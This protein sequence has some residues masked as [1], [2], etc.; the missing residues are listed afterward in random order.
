MLTITISTRAALILATVALT[1]AAA[2]PFAVSRAEGGEPAAVAS[3]ESRAPVST[4]FQYQGRLELDGVPA[5]GTHTLGFTL[6]S[7]AVA[8]APVDSPITATVPVTD[9]V[10]SVPLDFGEDAFNGDARW[11]GV[12]V[13][14]GNSFVPLGPRQA[15]RATPYALHSLT[16]GPHDHI[17]DEWENLANGA[18]GLW[19]NSQ[20]FNSKSL[21]LT[22]TGNCSIAPRVCYGLYSDANYSG[23]GS[24]FGG[25]GVY[26]EGSNAG[27]IGSGPFIGMY[28]SSPIT[29]LQAESSG[30]LALKAMATGLAAGEYA[31]T[32]EATGVGDGLSVKSGGDGI[33]V[34]A[35]GL[36]VRSFGVA[37]GLYGYASGS[38]GTG[39][40]GIANVNQGI[41]VDGY[42]SSS[43]GTG[44]KGSGA[45]V[46]VWG[47]LL[48]GSGWAGYFDGGA[49]S[50]SGG[51]SGPSDIRL[52]HN[53]RDLNSALAMVKALRPV[54]FEYNS[55]PGERL[56]LIAQEV[57]EVV[58]EVVTVD[59]LTEEGMLGV[60]YSE[61]VPVL[62]KA[63]Q[64]QQA[65]IEML[66]AA[67]G[68]E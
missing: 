25:V 56:G 26:G 41:G 45:N 24:G 47:N 1:L 63:M 4:A 57:Q 52:K 46:G 20:G 14:V 34:D 50:S 58:P 37:A 16:T 11:L 13:L 3:V 10:F 40:V 36:G 66:K 44:V 60:K 18:T 42:S 48:D 5:N 38:L 7:D 64:E 31:A 8:N 67:L 9:G 54:R 62:I 53:V 49:V 51:Y 65:E 35:A 23:G 43:L 17:E 32:I 39:V 6:Y 2:I 15:L 29:A 68:I 27:V 28:A 33:V 12:E 19:I 61:L 55:M 59:T 22:N 21:Y 30:G